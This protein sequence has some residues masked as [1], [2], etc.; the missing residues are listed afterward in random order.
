MTA[1]PGRPAVSVTALAAAAFVVSAEAR[2]VAPLLPTIAASLGVSVQAA[3]S[4]VYLYLLP[5]GICQLGYGPLGDRL[6]KLRV[7]RA[8]MWALGLGTVACAFA[9]SLAVLDVLRLATGV[10]AAAVFPMALA[11]LGDTLPYAERPQAI[12]AL[13][14]GA[15]LG[16][17]LSMALGGAIGQFLSWRVAFAVYGALALVV[18]GHLA[19]G[20]RRATAAAGV[21]PAPSP[22]RPRRAAARPPW[23]AGYRELLAARGTRALYLTTAV[24]GFF[25]FGPFTY[26][27]ALL[28][29]RDGLD[30]LTAS[31]VLVANGIGGVAGSRVVAP[32]VR[33]LGER[34]A[35]VLG[36]LV[37]GVPYLLLAAPI[38]VALAPF[39][40]FVMGAGWPVAHAVLQT[41]AT[42]VPG[43]TRGSSLS[44]FAFSLFVGG[45]IGT[46]ALGLLIDGPGYAAVMLAGGLG[47]SVF[48]V[49]AP[50]WL[51]LPAAT[52]AAATATARGR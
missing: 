5:Y 34:G 6:G 36:G 4:A 52:G 45:S 22:A 49:G 10:A 41:R 28:Q 2:V 1:A 26:V 48:A 42:A 17:T 33:R 51:G 18:A 20:A 37:C 15:A 9:P 11:H 8:V 30:Q 38:P 13:M 24:E 14:T 29:V 32:A 35:L 40:L 12:G 7:I 43:A 27:S 23:W 31:L 16:Q 3:A 39:A 50:G 44:L 47:L 46:A 25:A 19:G 21:A